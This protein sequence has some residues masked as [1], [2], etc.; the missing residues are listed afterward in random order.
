MH[1]LLSWGCVL[2]AAITF[3]LVFGWM[4]FRTRLDNQLTYAT[5]LFG[6]PVLQFRLKTVFA[7]KRKTLATAQLRLRCP[8]PARKHEPFQSHREVV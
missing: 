4:H 2:A 1:M 6:F 8:I 7:C 5:Y 3:P